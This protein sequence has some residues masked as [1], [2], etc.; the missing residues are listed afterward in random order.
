MEDPKIKYFGRGGL[1]NPIFWCMRGLT[2][3]IIFIFIVWLRF[4]RGSRKCGRGVLGVKTV[5]KAFFTKK[6]HCF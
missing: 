6:T 2:K 4:A 5:G 3:P 1:E